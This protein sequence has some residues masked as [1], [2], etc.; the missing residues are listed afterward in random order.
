MTYTREQVEYQAEIA[1]K[2]A[3]TDCSSMLRAQQSHI[4]A[5]EKQYAEGL[6]AWK[7][8]AE[9]HVARIAELEAELA[10]ANAVKPE[11]LR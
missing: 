7:R 6:A 4:E 2:M 10:A 3:W 8:N 9:W 5:L 11:C 1:D